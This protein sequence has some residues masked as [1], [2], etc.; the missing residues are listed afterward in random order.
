MLTDAFEPCPPLAE[1]TA[2]RTAFGVP[3]E[4]NHNGRSEAQ[5]PEEMSV[6]RVAPQ[7]GATAPG[8]C[9]SLLPLFQ[10]RCATADRWPT[11]SSRGPG[12]HLCSLRASRGPWA[13]PSPPFRQA[14][15]LRLSSDLLSTPCRCLQVGSIDSAHLS[16]AIDPP[17][18]K[19]SPFLLLLLPGFPPPGA[20]T[21]GP[22]PPS[23]VEDP[24]LDPGGLSG[25]RGDEGLEGANVFNNQ[26]GPIGQSGPLL[27]HPVL[28]V[29]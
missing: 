10:R 29:A 3:E 4:H 27:L 16:V 9:G 20:M 26:M 18:L 5:P 15:P 23:K 28:P 8:G 21:L 6:L 14:S 13:C 7:V 22:P 1:W 11:R 19:R 2:A 24:P 25:R 12:W 17:G